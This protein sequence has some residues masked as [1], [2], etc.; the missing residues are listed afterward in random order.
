[1]PLLYNWYDIVGD[2]SLNGNGVH[3]EAQASA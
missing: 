3:A 1:V 2:G